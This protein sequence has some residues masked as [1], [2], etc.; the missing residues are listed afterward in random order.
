MSQGA[1]WL[2]RRF[3]PSHPVRVN[4]GHP[5]AKELASFL[6]WPRGR[7]FYDAVTQ[8]LAGSGTG[9]AVAATSE[10]EAL[11]FNGTARTS[12][13]TALRNPRGVSPL[14][15][16]VIARMRLT[17]KPAS[18]WAIAAQI[19]NVGGTRGAGVGFNSSGFAVGASSGGNGVMTSPDATDWLNQWVTVGGSS[20]YTDLNTPAAVAKGRSWVNGRKVGDGSASGGITSPGVAATIYMGREPLNYN[21]FFNGDIAW[22]AFF[23][24]FLTDDEHDWWAKR[25]FE[26]LEQ[27]SNVSFFSLPAVS[28]AVSNIPN[29]TLQLRQAV[30]R[31]SVY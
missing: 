8:N 22:A 25:P 16:T 28:G 13:T 18:N 15:T 23:T 30:K 5:M 26:V 10:G 3:K 20:A 4:Q 29:R 14:L 27:Q 19:D 1:L 2:P 21:Q 9:Q 6:I 12:T 7:T 11:R 24:R 17:T 31:A